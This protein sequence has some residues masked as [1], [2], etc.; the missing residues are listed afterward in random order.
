V[1]SILVITL[2]YRAVEY[3]KND[4]GTVLISSITKYHGIL[5][6]II[7]HIIMLPSIYQKSVKHK[8]VSLPQVKI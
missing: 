3:Q 6:F 1:V 4:D 7:M 8:V 2:P 5:S